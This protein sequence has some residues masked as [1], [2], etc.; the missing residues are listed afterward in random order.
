VTHNRAYYQYANP[1]FTSPPPVP[2]GASPWASATPPWAIGDDFA[3]QANSPALKAGGTIRN[4][5]AALASVLH[6]FVGA[7][8]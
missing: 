7:V 4:A 5:T 8:L 2:G 6:E 3:L 1:M